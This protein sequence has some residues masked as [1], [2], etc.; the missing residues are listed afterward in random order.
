MVLK[1]DFHRSRYFLFWGEASRRVPRRRPA[2]HRPHTHY[3]PSTPTPPLSLI[4]NYM[5]I[6]YFMVF[7]A[8]FRPSCL[9]LPHTYYYTSYVLSH[10]APQTQLV[11]PCPPHS[12]SSPPPPPATLLNRRHK[13][14][15]LP[16]SPNKKYCTRQRSPL[17]PQRPTLHL[18]TPLN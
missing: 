13:S 16:R 2:H 4:I 14:K 9:H 10:S 7:K 12:P 5:Y 1:I 6:M 11:T 18:S 15:L 17:P 8:T 3:S